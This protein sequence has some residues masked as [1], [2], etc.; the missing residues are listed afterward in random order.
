MP[1]I[2]VGSIVTVAL[3]VATG[4]STTIR[5]GEVGIRQ[6]FG[7]LAES[8]RGPGTVVHSP[9][10]VKFVRVPV[11]TSNVEVELDLPSRE[12]LNVRA[13]VSILY[14]VRPDAASLLIETVGLGYE[15]ELVMPVF[16]SAAADI[17]SRYAAKDMHS[18]QRQGIEEEIRERMAQVLEPR[19]VEVEAVL[20][21]SIA[22]PNRLYAAVEEKLSA[23][24]TSQRMQFVLE[25]ERQEAERRRIEAEGI[26]DAQR[27]LEEGL[28]PGVLQWRSLEAFMELSKSPNTKVIVTDGS[29]P[30]LVEGTE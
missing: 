28:T 3:L 11:R 13:V 8:E 14:R 9:I 15:N 18:G 19:G 27:I 16:R 4:C 20:M 21:K 23:E 17:S 24:Q 29:L 25:Q 30:M 10:G 5:P 2:V 12:G 6:S 7:R 1:R 22:L 26:R